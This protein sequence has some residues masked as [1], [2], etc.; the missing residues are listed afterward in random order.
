MQG[1]TIFV[2][3]L[4][5]IVITALVV[6]SILYALHIN[7]YSETHTFYKNLLSV[8]K[9][10]TKFKEADLDDELVKTDFDV[11]TLTQ[12]QK[13]T[14]TNVLSGSVSNNEYS[15]IA[16]N[17]ISSAIATERANND[18]DKNNIFL[19]N[20][21]SILSESDLFSNSPLFSNIASNDFSIANFNKNA[22]NNWNYTITNM[23]TNLFSNLEENGLT[24]DDNW[25]T[26]FNK[27]FKLSQLEVCDNTMNNC[28][29]FGVNENN[30]LLINSSVGNSNVIKFGNDDLVID[31]QRSGNKGVFHKNTFY[32]IGSGTGTYDKDSTYN[33][34]ST[35]GPT[36]NIVSTF[37]N[38]AEQPQD[39]QNMI[40]DKQKLIVNGGSQSGSV[41]PFFHIKTEST[42]PQYSLGSITSLALTYN[43]EYIYVFPYTRI[44]DFVIQV[45][46]SS[47]AT[48]Y[49]KIENIS[50]SSSQSSSQS[51]SYSIT[52]GEPL[53]TSEFIPT[54]FTFKSPSGNFS[55]S[56][57]SGS[58]TYTSKNNINLLLVKK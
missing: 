5:F 6:L 51:N 47:S 55:I 20:S 1:E 15:N 28:Y 2:L 52:V 41:N 39:I 31:T 45:E 43:P 7:K 11:D 44:F 24:I 3:F 26:S 22:I 35:G 33:S 16:N 34:Y 53:A 30:E 56:N 38:I 13:D 10:N 50:S 49:V 18:T 17:M 32:T 37:D 9:E 54:N 40:Y 4:V 36:T 14:L 57:S 29:S 12:Q 42:L 21:Y 19:K 23:A 27:P 46:D 48:H 58:T 8:M 25:N